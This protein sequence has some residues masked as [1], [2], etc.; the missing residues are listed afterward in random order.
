MK[1]ILRLLF[2]LLPAL[3]MAAPAQEALIVNGLSIAD[4]RSDL[5]PGVSYAAAE[6]FA[7]AFGAQFR[8]ETGRQLASFEL[9][10]RIASIEVFDSAGDAAAAAEALKLDGRPEGGP[11]GV[12][13]DGTVYVPVR[14]IARVFYGTVSHVPERGVIVVFDRGSLE[15]VQKPAPEGDSYERLVLEISRPVPVSV[16]EDAGERLVRFRLDRTDTRAAEEYEGTYFS[17]LEIVP[18]RG[19][20][21]VQLQL[22]PD[23]RFE[24]WQV[25]SG[26]GFHLVIDVFPQPDGDALLHAP[27]PLV[28]LD[29][30]RGGTDQGI[31]FP[32]VGSESTLTLEFSQRVAGELLDLGYRVELTREDDSSVSQAVRAHAGTGADL[33]ISIHGAAVSTGS[34]TVYYLGEA[35]SSQLLSAVIRRNA[36]ELA[37][38]L[39]TDSVRRQILLGLVPDLEA[40]EDYAQ[41]LSRELSRNLGMNTRTAAAPLTVLTGAAGRG[42]LIELG[43][44]DLRSQDVAQGFAAAVARILE[45]ND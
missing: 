37:A 6:P 25:P 21:E 40:G 16:H 34:A 13:Q 31:N 43:P 18:E 36:R 15:A 7:E 32:A 27:R 23:S 38:E 39:D 44:G 22:E 3:T 30:A 35:E 9:G 17:T 24:W 8:F 10:G 11:G 4:V 2:V 41:A 45:E 19:R 33:F 28:V 14:Q 1:P 29:P 20:V 12:I 5:V 26:R 42:L